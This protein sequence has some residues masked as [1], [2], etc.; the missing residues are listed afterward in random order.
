MRKCLL[1]LGMLTNCVRALGTW[2]R[3][4]CQ[5]GKSSWAH[6]TL[7]REFLRL[8]PNVAGRCSHVARVLSS[9]NHTRAFSFEGMWPGKN[10]GARAEIGVTSTHRGPFHVT[11]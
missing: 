11:M 8:H 2:S 7:V 4:V 10:A 6:W 1:A 9:T 3:C 5:G